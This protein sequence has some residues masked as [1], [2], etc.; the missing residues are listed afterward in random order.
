MY[1]AEATV[2][3]AIATDEAGNASRRRPR[4][5]SE[6]ARQPHQLNAN[7]ENAGGP[8]LGFQD[9]SGAH[10]GGIGPS[11]PAPR[12]PHAHMHE[13]SCP[14]TTHAHVH[15]SPSPHGCTCMR[16]MHTRRVA[17]AEAKIEVEVVPLLVDHQV[18]VVPI[19]QLEQPHDD[20]VRRER[21]AKVL[22]R[23]FE[24]GRLRSA[25]PLDVQ[26]A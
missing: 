20:R 25:V 1:V 11:D 17:E 23:L 13:E 3:A 6:T 10:Q 8:Q 2:V 15:A 18:A 22:L 14:C 21:L 9:L 7:A 12:R 4:A 5:H 24:A 16:L 26:I 19:A